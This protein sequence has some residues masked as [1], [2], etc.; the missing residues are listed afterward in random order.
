MKA[1][2]PRKRRYEYEAVALAKLQDRVVK[3]IEEADLS[4]LTTAYVS[5]LESDNVVMSVVDTLLQLGYDVSVKKNLGVFA[6]NL[7]RFPS[8]TITI[9]LGF[10]PME[11]LE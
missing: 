1:Y 6:T 4:G 3:A 11:E 5:T 8:V 9:N 7:I 2:T 10:L